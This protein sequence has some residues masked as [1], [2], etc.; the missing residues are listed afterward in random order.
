LNS[1]ASETDDTDASVVL[2]QLVEAKYSYTA[3]EVA[4]TSR[5]LVVE[6]AEALAVAIGNSIADALAA[7]ITETNFGATAATQTVKAAASTDFTTL[8]AIT[9]VDGAWLTTALLAG[10]AAA[11]AAQTIVSCAAASD[12]WL[13]TLGQLNGNQTVL[14]TQVDIL[15]T[16]KA[17]FLS[18]L[19]KP[20]SA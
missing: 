4:S 5:D 8:A 11:T 14:Q 3:A 9:A 7:L 17:L 20:M 2:N 10:G 16:L 19:R 13:S 1:T 18:V 15:A 6:H 12:T